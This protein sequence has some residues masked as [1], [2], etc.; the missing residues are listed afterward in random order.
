MRGGG[1]QKMGRLSIQI[2][3]GTLGEAERPTVKDV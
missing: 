1:L 3:G 2:K